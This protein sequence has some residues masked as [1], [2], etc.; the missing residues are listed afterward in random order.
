MVR[1]SR[2]RPFGRGRPIR[3]P[4]FIEYCKDRFSHA[5]HLSL[6]RYSRT[7]VDSSR[8]D[9]STNLER[10]KHRSDSL[11]SSEV[12]PKKPA[13]RSS[14][15]N[16]R[17]C[18]D[19]TRRRQCKPLRANPSGA[20]SLLKRLPRPVTAPH[21]HLNLELLRPVRARPNRLTS[22]ARRRS[23]SGTISARCRRGSERGRST[24][25]KA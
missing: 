16:R 2:A 23:R 15:S 13:A 4:P 9:L 25:A 12:K 11:S 5:L 24:L 21:L 6:S 3:R 7:P 1:P 18:L 14:S 10:T 8:K 17:P 19:Q 22:R 20:V